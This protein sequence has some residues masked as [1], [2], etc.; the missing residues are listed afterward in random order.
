MTAEACTCAY[1]GRTIVGEP[2]CSI[3]RDAFAVG[4][5]VPLCEGCGMWPIPS[6]EEIW[7]R[8][9]ML[10]KQERERAEAEFEESIK[11][12]SPP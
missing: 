6:C 5:E 8:I 9:S 3:H 2:K 12:R 10:S 1:C 7:D 11:G 4:P